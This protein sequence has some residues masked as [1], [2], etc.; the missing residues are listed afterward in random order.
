MYKGYARDEL[1]RWD[2]VIHPDV[3][4]NSPAGRGV[5][6]RDKLKAF[7]QA[8]IIAF[9]PRTDLIDH[10][11]AGDRGLVTVNLHWTH[12]GGPF[13]G[14]APTGRSGTS[15]ETFLLRLRD[16]LVTHWDVADNSLDLATYLHDQGLD[17]PRNV[18]L[19]A[20]IEG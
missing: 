4:A 16:G 1:D 5:V 11:V 13:W 8:F 14:I 17:M 12:E 6:G 18:V 19:P 7:N 20:L 15:V 9:R 10:Y 3:E 2:A